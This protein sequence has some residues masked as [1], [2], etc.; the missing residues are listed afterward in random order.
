MIVAV[1]G[2]T[3]LIGSALVPRLAAGS[4]LVIR[5][6]RGA[7]ATAAG[8]RQAR[9]DAATGAIEPSDLA[10]VDAVVHLAGESVAGGRWTEARKRRIRES[11]VPATRRL[12]ETLARLP[13]P[14]RALLCASAIGYY[15]D[16]G[17]EVLRE[18]SPPGAG[19]LADLCREWEAAAELAA[20]HGIRVVQL[21]IGLVL[22]PK[23]G[24][25]A[26]MLPVFRLGGGGPVGAGAQWMS[27]IGID[28]TL[29]AILHAL[30]TEALA[31]PINVVAPA[32]VTNREF[33]RTLG[34][35]LR[36]P[37][38]VPF[39]AVAA[40]LLLGQM[41]DEL[42][43]ASARVV[44]ARL[45]ATGYAFRDATLEGALRRLLAL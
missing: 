39:P 36:R 18:E 9:W 43:L 1:T 16:R 14:P 31:G 30:T 34:R 33:G 7:P 19:F 6:V 12:C 29:G 21:R 10:G 4:H 13:Q 40:R 17:D 26:A 35:V 27:W 15:G 23:G 45:E 42:L 8:E 44:P 37:A 11:R 20:R 25:L 32:P 24:A 28:D 5:L 2:S 22:S 41:A 38:I 3:G